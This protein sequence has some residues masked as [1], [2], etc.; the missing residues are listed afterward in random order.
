[1]ERTKT[2]KNEPQA[3]KGKVGAILC[4]DIHIHESN[5]VCRLDDFAG[6][7][8]WKKLNW[9]KKLQIELNC[10]VIHAGDL[11]EYWK[12]SPELISKTITHLPF[13]F[14]TVYGNHD[15]PQHNVELSYKSGVHTLEKAGSLKVLN[16]CHW[17][18]VPDRVADVMK[19]KNKSIMVWHVMTYQGREPF[20]GCTAPKGASLLRKYPYDLIVT[21]DN[22]K[23]FVEEHEGR[24][25]VNPGSL[26]RTK[27]DQMDFKPRVYLWYPES[28][29]VEAIYV[30]IDSNA[31]SREHLEDKEKRDERIEAFISTLN[32]DWEA[33]MSFEEN[34]ERFRQTNNVP[35]SV[36]QIIYKAIE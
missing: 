33:E 36:M 10:P 9:L 30:P 1:M 21:G 18:Q 34:I 12:A 25:L 22:H 4:A 17:G 23:P 5:P 13:Q 26:F 15:L 7:T 32:E 8:Q 31:I 27:A 14:Y 24:L 6:L 20:P 16:G 29:T 11:F 19:I 3:H 2:I 28:N 35:E